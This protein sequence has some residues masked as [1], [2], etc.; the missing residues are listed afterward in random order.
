MT[1]GVRHGVT[2]PIVVTAKSLPN[3]SHT[4]LG[5]ERER[6]PMI[7]AGPEEL[8][9]ALRERERS[10]GG[11]LGFVEGHSAVGEVDILPRQVAEFGGSG[12][13]VEKADE[14]PAPVEEPPV[15][16]G[17]EQRISITTGEPPKPTARTMLSG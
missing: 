2:D 14:E 12:A 17:L 8:L 7:T 6:M 15:F 13:E 5:G 1:E 10:G 11:V 9:D 16:E 4:S 3:L